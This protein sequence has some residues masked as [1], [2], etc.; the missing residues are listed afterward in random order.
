MRVVVLGAGVVGVTTAFYLAKRGFQVTVVDRADA[1]ASGASHANAGQLSYSF[2][3]ALAQPGMPGKLPGLVF[4]ADPAIRLRPLLD[5]NFVR[6]GMRFV[7]QCTE[8]NY[9]QNTTAVLQLAMRSS[10]LMEQLRDEVEFDFA[11]RKAGKLVLYRSAEDLAAAEQ[12]V[13]LKRGFGC[14]TTLLSMREAYEIEPSLENMREGYAGAVYSKDDHLGDARLFSIRLA[15]SL[16]DRFGVQ[17]RLGCE[18]QSLLK[19]NGRVSGVQLQDGVLAADAVVVCLGAWSRTFLEAMPSGQP[20]IP[21][22]GYSVTLPRGRH[23]PK[24]SIS[25]TEQRIVFSAMNADVRI[26]GFADFVGFD[27]SADASRIGLLLDIAR[28]IAPEA[29]DYS[30]KVRHEWGGFRPMTANSRPI[31]GPASVP[32]LWLNCGHGMLGWTLA[33]ATGFD[34]AQQLAPSQV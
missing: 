21:V 22:R 1:V 4:G 28:A 17:F 18:A 27:D 8:K 16:Q 6:W 19:S 32:G 29:A 26:A 23:S 12:S 7:R 30:A 13:L 34:I 20:L 33:C 14:Q 15:E 2:T 9:R 31:V 25:D 11:F 5:M 10:A 3:D 24:V